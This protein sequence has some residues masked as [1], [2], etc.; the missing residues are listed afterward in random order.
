LQTGTKLPAIPALDC[1]GA[2]RN[3]YIAPICQVQQK[4][5]SEKFID[6]ERQGQRGFRDR[7][8]VLRIG[9][10]YGRQKELGGLQGDQSARRR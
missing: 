1:L 5:A 4:R 3:L 9:D 7:Q 8:L 10:R 6:P 2:A